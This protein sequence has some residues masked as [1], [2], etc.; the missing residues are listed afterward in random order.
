MEEGGWSTEVTSH[1]KA[2]AKERPGLAS[3]TP[4]RCLQMGEAPG[5]R[6]DQGPPHRTSQGTCCPSCRPW[7]S[8]GRPHVTDA[9]SPAGWFCRR[10]CG[11][12]LCER[13]VFSWFVRRAAAWMPGKKQ[14][15]CSGSQPPGA[16]PSPRGTGM[17]ILELVLQ[18]RPLLRPRWGLR[19]R[20]ALAGNVMLRA[21]P[22]PLPRAEQRANDRLLSCC[23]S[24][25]KPL[26]GALR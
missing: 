20:K 16:P 3:E 24:G 4:H 13:T 5:L 23:F 19:T 8:H 1:Q 25:Q 15:C 9:E 6:S 22:Q 12:A 26:E 7:L 2:V 10:T 11:A 21:V 18:G 14:G 17:A